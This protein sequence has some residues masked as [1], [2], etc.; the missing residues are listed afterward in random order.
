M[1]RCYSCG[2]MTEPGLVADLYAAHGIYVAVENVPADVCRQCGERYYS[3]DT[4]RRLLSLT[5]EARRGAVAGST[6]Q[7]L[8]FDFGREAA[9]AAMTG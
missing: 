9:L 3:P 2:G 5:E 6:M 4:T 7:L 1:I 8:V